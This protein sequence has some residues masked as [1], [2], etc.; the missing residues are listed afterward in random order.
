MHVL[1]LMVSFF[2]FAFWFLTHKL[3]KKRRVDLA[4]KLEKLTVYAIL[5]LN[6]IIFIIYFFGT[7]Y[8]SDNLY[9]IRKCKD[10]F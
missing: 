9:S 2:G 7:R 4:L 3:V 1:T 5:A 8:I 6:I 10:D